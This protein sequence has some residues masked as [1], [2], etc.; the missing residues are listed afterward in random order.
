MQEFVARVLNTSR[1]RWLRACPLFEPFAPVGAAEIEQAE[2]KAGGPLP[3]ELRAWLLAA[4]YGDVDETLSFRQDW[5]QKIETGHLTGFVI[6]AQDDLGN[7][8]AYSQT[9]GSIYFLARSSPQYA[10]LA[11]S[12]RAFMEELENRDF[13]LG[14]WTN[15]LPLA[16]SA[17]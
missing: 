1:K 3:V 13:Q 15:S 7:F 16:S 8:Y 12:F 10:K 14:A 6:F 9:D 4:G 2:R 17:G 5:F 11:S